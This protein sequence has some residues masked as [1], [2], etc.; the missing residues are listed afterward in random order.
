MD[1]VAAGARA[2]QQQDVP[3][4]VGG[5]AGQVLDARDA[6][7]HGVDQRVLRIAVV[8]VDFAGHV[9]NADAVSIPADAVHHA[10]Q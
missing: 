3:G 10:F 9:G 1:S 2:G 6:D 7:A 5:G 4:A 8:E